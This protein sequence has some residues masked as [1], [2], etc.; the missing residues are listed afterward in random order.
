M[1]ASGRDPSL[2]RIERDAVVVCV[3][4]AALAFGVTRDIWP[5]L[6]VLGGGVL[7]G[8]SYVSIK[9][10]ATVLADLAGGG[11]QA[12]AARTRVGRNVAKLVLRYALLALLAYVM[13]GRL[14]MH[15]LALLAG[16]SSVVAA[17]SIEAIR[18]LLKKPESR[19]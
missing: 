11:P 8:V 4:L 7:I 13:I 3:A 2:D 6:G 14:R 18:L 17:V 9:G 19:G 12:A 10:V 15:P 16:A 1:I 5:G